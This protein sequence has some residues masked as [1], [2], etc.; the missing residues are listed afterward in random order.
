[1]SI[2]VSEILEDIDIITGNANTG[3]ITNEDKIRRLN[4]SVEWVKRKLGL[5]NDERIQTIKFSADQ[6]YYDLDTDVDEIFGV[7]W[8]EDN[9]NLIDN[10]WNPA[11]YDYILKKR[12]ESK[13]QLWALT[14]INGTPQIV[15]WGDNAK[16]GL[17]LETFD[18]IGDWVVGGDASSLALDTNIVYEGGDSFMFDISNSTGVASIV[19]DGISWNLKDLFENSGMIKFWQRM[20]SILIDDITLYLYTDD[21]NYYTITVSELDNGNA[22]TANA[23]EKVGFSMDDAVAVGTPDKEDITKVRIEYDLG[24]TFVSATDFRIDQMFTSYPDEVDVLYYSSYKGTTSAGVNL[25]NF[26]AITDIAT[27]GNDDLRDIVA[28]RA[29]YLSSPQ[30]RADINW[31]AVYKQ[32][33]LEQLKDFAR[34]NPRKRNSNSFFSSI[35]RGKR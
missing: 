10:Q 5:P 31:L 24:S 29:A 7:A 23:W 22:W 20:T 8:H 6:I 19:N 30:L 1:M 21:S 11:P 15:L 14:H 33:V 13:K 16:G 2:T 18:A 32:E 4:R 27:F 28:W 35:R 34:R 12:A 9:L 25:T 17:T 3:N 26:T